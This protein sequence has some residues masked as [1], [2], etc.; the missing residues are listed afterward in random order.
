MVQNTKIKILHIN[1]D[2]YNIQKKSMK[3]YSE[4]IREISRY[5][6]INEISINDRQLNSL[7]NW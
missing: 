3:I 5:F 1:G 7:N 4:L 6:D 2:H